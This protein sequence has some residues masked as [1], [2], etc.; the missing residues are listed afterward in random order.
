VQLAESNS[1]QLVLQEWAWTTDRWV[2]GERRVLEETA[3]NADAISAIAAPDGQIAVMYGSLIDRDGTLTDEII[4]T[5]RQWQVEDPTASRTPLP[6]LTPT[7]EVL[8]TET[9]VPQPSPT[10]TATLSPVENGGPLSGSSGGIIVG[11]V[12]ALVLVAAIFAIGWR[13]TRAR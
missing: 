4:Y 8:P 2:A 10:P 9:P 5:G 11:V 13:M 12:V 7:P 6:T 3:V 1:G